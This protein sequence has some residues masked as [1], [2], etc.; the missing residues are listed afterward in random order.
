MQ[1]LFTA[2]FWRGILDQSIHWLI[3]A[4]PYL[5]VVALLALLGNRLIVF[6]LTR[7]RVVMLKHLKDAS[8]IEAAEVGKRIDTLLSILK[9]ALRAVLWTI[10]IMLVLRRLGIDIAPLIAGAGIAGLAV[11]FG[12]QE[13]VRDIISGFFVLLENQI[14]EGDVAEIN[15]TSGT[16]ERVG[17]RTIV[18]R[19][20]TGVVH[21]FQNGKIDTLSNMT[22]G[23]SAAVFDLRV[24]YKDDVDRVIA[25]M[26]STAQ[27]MADD[28]HWRPL[29]LSPLEVMGVDAFEED[30]LRIRARLKTRPSQQWAAAR[31]FRKRLK[32]AFD[33][34][35]IAFPRPQRILAW[36]TDRETSSVDSAES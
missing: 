34:A 5:A 32:K 18:L 17:L 36:E 24:N 12:A 14:R 15:G 13:L 20:A 26:E 1:R 9:S 35:G 28:D 33:A 11:G 7:V 25:V 29:L 10:V 8:T 31:E 4:L 2:D 23:W 27:E 22:K 6:L 21:V 16:V 3:D 19:D 30:A